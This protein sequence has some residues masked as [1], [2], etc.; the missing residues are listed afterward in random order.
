VDLCIHHEEVVVDAQEAGEKL[1][2]VLDR[3]GKDEEDA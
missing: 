3:T 2:E 1:V